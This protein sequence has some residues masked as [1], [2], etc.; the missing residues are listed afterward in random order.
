[1]TS[2]KPFKPEFYKQH[3]VAVDFYE[4]EQKS[5]MLVKLTGALPN[6]SN[7]RMD[8]D[9]INQ[10]LAINLLAMRPI[11]LLLD[12]SAL[13]YSFGNSFIHALSPLFE[14]QI[15]ESKFNIAFLLS[16]LNKYGLAGLWALDLNE[17]PVNI[18]FDYEKALQY[19]EAEYDK[20]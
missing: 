16:D 14:L 13:S 5:I 6:G 11:S 9:Y 10:Q 19:A 8:C 4:H 15:F 18:F 7:A 3:N 2:F 1:M 17:P 20:L 12:M